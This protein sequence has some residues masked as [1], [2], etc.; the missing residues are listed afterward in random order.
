MHRARAF[1]T[2]DDARRRRSQL[3]GQQERM[4]PFSNNLR[5]AYLGVFGQSVI[6]LEGHNIHPRKVKETVTGR[7]GEGLRQGGDG[8]IE[9]RQLQLLRSSCVQRNRSKGCDTAV[10]RDGE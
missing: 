6:L 4:H 2:P 9:M 7:K 8:E 3:T 10:R 5:W 1:E